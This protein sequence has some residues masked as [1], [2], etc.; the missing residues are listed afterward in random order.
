MFT[1]PLTFFE[2]ALEQLDLLLHR[3]IL[4]L[5]ASYELSLDEFRGLYVSDEQV[6]RLVKQSLRHRGTE[7]DVA[8]LTARAEEM[9]RKIE[10][11]CGAGLSWTRLV[12][13]FELSAFEQDVLLL[14]L[15]PE[16][17]PKY[18]TL[19]AY[20]NNDV[21]RKWPTREL[22]LRLFA[23]GTVERW[24]LRRELL[25]ESALFG[26]GLLTE[27]EPAPQHPTSL[28]VGF[29]PSPLVI[30]FALGLPLADAGLAG[31]TLREVEQR[32][33]K[34]HICSAEQRNAIRRA[35]DLCRDSA[36]RLLLVFEGRDG[37]GG[38]EAAAVL[39]REL[40]C[41]LLEVDLAVA[42]TAAE[43]L[44]EGYGSLPYGSG[45]SR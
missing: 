28:T 43:S 39:C 29:S 36:D 31:V 11:R 18:E 3:E 2:A 14:A 10:T 30:R 21:S 42:R 4:R 45:S 5:R 13:E 19:Y 35:A 9:R 6:D 22:A 33:T 44:F 41:P 24:A 34:A 1:D 16:I 7:A 20:L 15:A 26:S 23:T 8:G 17:D 12:E 27:L 37:S 25:P 40:G 32:A 38:G